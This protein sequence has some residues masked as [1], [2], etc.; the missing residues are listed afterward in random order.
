M[1]TQLGPF[2][3]S[4]W[5]ASGALFLL[6]GNLEIFLHNCHMLGTLDEHPSIF[7]GAQVSNPLRPPSISSFRLTGLLQQQIFLTAH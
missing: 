6:L 4:T 2:S 7:R 5:H 1:G 3:S